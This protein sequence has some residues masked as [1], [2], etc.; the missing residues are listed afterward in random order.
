MSILIHLNQF[1]YHF[2]FIFKF[3]LKSLLKFQIIFFYS[4]DFMERIIILI[5]FIIILIITIIIINL[6]IMAF[7]EQ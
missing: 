4:L 3:F 6:L 5:M 2:I 1:H 7:L